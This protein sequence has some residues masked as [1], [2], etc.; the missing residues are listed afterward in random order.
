MRRFE[1]SEQFFVISSDRLNEVRTNMYGFSVQKEGIVDYYNFT[2]ELL[3]GLD[4]NGVYVCVENLDQ[5]IVIRQDAAGCFGIYVY[6]KEGYFALSNSF[7]ELFSFLVKDRK[8]T[9]NRA[10]SDHMMI[11]GLCCHSCKDTLIEEISMLPRDVV[12]TISKSSGEL[13]I[14]R[15]AYSY[16]VIDPTTDVGLKIIDE[17]YLKWARVFSRISENGNVVFD[18]SGGF[19]SRLALIFALSPFSRLDKI[20]VNS[21]DN[22]L[23][24]HAED[25][26]IAT[27]IAK[28][29][30]FQLNCD[31][32]LDSRARKLQLDEILKL[33]M[34]I[35]MPF[36]DEMHWCE[37]R[38][39]KRRFH[40]NGLGGEVLRDHWDVPAAKI[41][42]GFMNAAGSWPHR[43]GESNKRLLESEIDWVRSRY[44]ISNADSP[45]ISTWWYRDSRN[46]HHCG[47]EVAENFYRNQYELSPLMD[48]GLSRLKR[49][50]PGCEDN[51][52][53]YSIIVDRF[54]PGL[55]EFAFDSKRSIVRETLVFAKNVNKAHPVDWNALR[56][57]VYAGSIVLAENED[58][59][60]K[61]KITNVP[62]GGVN[63][64]LSMVF[65]S[66][67]FSARYMACF[68]KEYYEQSAKWRREHDFYPLRRIY[69]A[70][71]AELIV[72][73]LQE[74]NDSIGYCAAHWRDCLNAAPVVSVILPIYNMEKYLRECLDTVTGQSL[75][76]IEIICVDD[77]STDGT[78]NILDEYRRKD[79]RV[80]VVRQENQG[81]AVA[82]NVGLDLADGDWVAFMDPDDRYP[83]SNVLEKLTECAQA[84]GVDICGGSLCAMN[85]AGK[86]VDKK[87]LGDNAGYVFTED[88][89][90]AYS[91]YQFDYGYWRFVYRRQFLADNKI[92][93]PNLRRFQD[94]PFFVKAMICAS[95]FYA[96]STPTYC[97][98]EGEGYK[99]VDWTSGDFQKA[100]HYVMGVKEVM[101]M[102]DAAG[103]KRLKSLM[104]R[105][106][107]KGGGSFIWK[108]GLSGCI[109]DS[110][111]PVMTGLTDIVSVVVPCYNVEKYVGEC[112]DSLLAQTWRNLEIICVNDGSTDRTLD[113]LERYSKL[114]SRVRIITKSNGGLGAARNTG[115]M[116]ARGKYIYFLDSD[117]KLDANGIYDLYELAERESLDQIIMSARVFVD[118]GGEIQDREKFE[119][120]YRLAPD[121]CNI[122][123]SGVD[124]VVKLCEKQIMPVTQQLR[125]FKLSYLRDIGFKNPEGILHEDNAIAFTSLIAARRAM[126]IPRK[127]YQRRLRPGS[128]M[129]TNDNRPERAYGLLANAIALQKEVSRHKGRLELAQ[130]LKRAVVG[131][132]RNAFWQIQ[133][134]NRDLPWCTR[135]E[136]A[137]KDVESLRAKLITV[138]R[139]KDAV[140]HDIVKLRKQVA[141]LQGSQNEATREIAALKS[142]EA[143]R[144]GMFVTW[145]A[146]WVYRILK[147]WRGGRAD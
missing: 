101:T 104:T 17:W 33:Y 134:L 130:T 118:E 141:A 110:L 88:G 115:M 108:E 23:H 105:R 45:E 53:L 63:A 44:G 10:F 72:S 24:T 75:K 97:Y 55:L 106:L 132:H 131:L 36:S 136:Q 8:L 120:Y 77:G 114:D 112:L 85:S 46:R 4:G 95:R 94:P 70:L 50:A 98:R 59:D 100:R 116:S 69:P 3:R 12:V 57:G 20:K 1:M 87:F 146:R 127:Y 27:D 41:L 47:K 86:I 103:M 22:N 64:F 29:F 124:L 60:D 54:C 122:V 81:A 126:A 137:L 28:R 49:N 76:N 84:N 140:L 7:Y 6:R 19:D 147:G 42:S 26:A 51:N 145:P 35:R 123:M 11:A 133:A 91:D 107:F 121:A 37:K 117:D 129:Q 99:A 90:V 31:R 73:Q 32:Y 15:I 40:V 78:I 92:R 14:D 9:F 13:R 139:E 2:P 80:M 25:F 144:V 111:S 74:R 142:S 113:V 65:D 82:R 119:A 52:L 39:I 143:Y 18:L 38:Y 61:I 79:S 138:G 96:L 135:R 21:I 68:G 58:V 89:I 5:S 71:V 30:G 109:A 125:F 62:E 16:S 93:F 102:A 66:M 83:S 34:R 43:L 67:R 128:I 56:N 48:I